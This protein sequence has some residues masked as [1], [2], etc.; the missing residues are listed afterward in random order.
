MLRDP[1]GGQGSNDVA[2]EFPLWRGPSLVPAVV[3]AVVVVAEQGTVVK[4]AVLIPRELAQ[5]Q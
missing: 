3:L 4:V 2:D 5:T 1:A